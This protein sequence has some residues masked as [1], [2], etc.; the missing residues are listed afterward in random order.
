MDALEKGNGIRLK[1]AQLKR[2]LKAGKVSVIDLLIDPPDYIK[3]MLVFDL[4]LACP[5][6]GRVKVNHVL[7]MAHVS[8]TI[9]I[10]GMTK[11][12]RHEIASMMRR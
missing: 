4:M 2:D 5:K 8:P 7:R 1:R 6:Y 9:R 11:R 3:K 12:Q 10:G